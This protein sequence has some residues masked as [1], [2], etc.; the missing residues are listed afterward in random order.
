MALTFRAIASGSSGNCYTLSDGATLIMLEAGIPWKKV[1]VALN[2]KTSE[3]AG[4]LCTHEH[5]DHSGYV[6]EAASCGIECYLTPETIAAKGLSGHRIHPIELFKDFAVGTFRIKAF[7]LEHDV[8]NCGF[9]ISGEGGEKAVYI[10]DSFY[11]RHRFGQLDLIAIECNWS[12]ETLA[13]D[14]PR[15]RAMRL[16]HSHFSLENVKRFLQANDLSRA[17]EIWL[18]HISKDNGDPEYFKSEIQKATG[19]PVYTL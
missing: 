5:N 3:V 4:L 18:L 8:A 16:Y 6:A 19:K 2:F 12:L 1:K 10:T 11:C 14:L 7:D 9:L 13:E 17:R 15:S